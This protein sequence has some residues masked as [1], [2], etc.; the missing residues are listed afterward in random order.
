[1]REN[2]DKHNEGIG[3]R[4]GGERDGRT[5]TRGW[6]KTMANERGLKDSPRQSSCLL[7]GLHAG[8]DDFFKS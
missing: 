8:D 2:Y 7:I 6:G 5:T 3:K 1:M 4:E